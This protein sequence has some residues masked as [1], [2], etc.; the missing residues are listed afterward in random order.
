[1]IQPTTVTCVSHWIDVS[2][3]HAPARRLKRAA[4]RVS[5]CRTASSSGTKPS[6]AAPHHSSGGNAAETSSPETAAATHGIQR[7]IFGL[8]FMISAD[9]LIEYG[10]FATAQQR[11]GRL[12]VFDKAMFICLSTTRAMNDGGKPCRT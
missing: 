9:M 11:A 7:S 10:S 4:D 3:Q 12:E 8:S 2:Q 5:V 1:M 6:Q